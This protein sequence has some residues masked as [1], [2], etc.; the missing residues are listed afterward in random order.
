[1]EDISPEIIEL[2][3]STSTGRVRKLD[4]ISQ[5]MSLSFGTMEGRSANSIPWI[6]SFEQ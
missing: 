1:M 2:T 6:V 5:T 3:F 4:D